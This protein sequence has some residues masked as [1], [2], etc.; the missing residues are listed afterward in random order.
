MAGT[1]FFAGAIGRDRGME[2]GTKDTPMIKS[3]IIG[4]K[5]FSFSRKY[6]RLYVYKVYLSNGGRVS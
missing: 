5:D 3:Y 2:I 4:N 1:G 6:L